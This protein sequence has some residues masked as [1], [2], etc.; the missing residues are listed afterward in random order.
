VGNVFIKDFQLALMILEKF[1]KD[2]S[3]K[4]EMKEK[5]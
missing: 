2:A 4:I 3:M 1:E 5:E